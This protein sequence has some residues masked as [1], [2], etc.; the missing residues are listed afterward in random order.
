MSEKRLSQYEKTVLAQLD[1]ILAQPEPQYCREM[2]GSDERSTCAPIHKAIRWLVALSMMFNHFK[3]LAVFFVVAT[4]AIVGIEHPLIS[5]QYIASMAFVILFVYTAIQILMRFF[6]PGANIERA[7]LYWVLYS[8]E[9]DFS[10]FQRSRIVHSINSYVY[11][12]AVLMV[13]YVLASLTGCVLLFRQHHWTLIISVP[14]IWFIWSLANTTSIG[15]NRKIFE[16]QKGLHQDDG[17]A[18]QKKPPMRVTC[19]VTVPLDQPTSGL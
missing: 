7:Y 2:L 11:A 17:A 3:L 5:G 16:L 8:D 9:S 13:L 18:E 14:A 4:V 6:N 10:V 1:L 12:F 15:L 19:R